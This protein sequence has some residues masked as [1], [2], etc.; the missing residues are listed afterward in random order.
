MFV[1]TRS[2]IPL[3]VVLRSCASFQCCQSF[4]VTA[5]RN[6]TTSAMLRNM[7]TII[8]QSPWAK[9]SAHTPTKAD[10]A[11]T[12]AGQTCDARLIKSTCVTCKSRLLTQ[13]IAE[14]AMCTWNSKTNKHQR[15]HR[16]Q[17]TSACFDPSGVPNMFTCPP[18]TD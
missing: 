16:E 9:G 17:H 5:Y 15:T 11:Y 3:N 1:S 18:L 14:L 12:V 10:S 4:L 2:C 6:T 8:V 13:H 7:S